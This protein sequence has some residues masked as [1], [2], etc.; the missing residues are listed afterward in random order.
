MTRFVVFANGLIVHTKSAAG[1]PVADVNTAK[2]VPG[3]T[4]FPQFVLHK[5][6]ISPLSAVNLYLPDGTD[7]LTVHWASGFAEVI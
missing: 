5:P 4:I 1:N 7:N 3:V 6:N 2:G